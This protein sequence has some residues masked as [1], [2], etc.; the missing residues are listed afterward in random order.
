MNL[1]NVKSLFRKEKFVEFIPKTKHLSRVLLG[2]TLVS[3]QDA[4][5][6]VTKNISDISEAEQGWWVWGVGKQEWGGGNEGGGDWSLH[7]Q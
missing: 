3:H 7:S 6:E 2:R 1:S 4:F 5:Y